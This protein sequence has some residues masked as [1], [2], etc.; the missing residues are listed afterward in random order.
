MEVVATRLP[1]VLVVT[2]RTF[3]DDRGEFWETYH[4][5]RYREA[6]IPGPLVQDNQSRSRRG[7]VRGLHFQRTH[8]QAKLVW[9][10]RGEVFDVAV[11]LREGAPTYGEWIGVHLSASN[12]KQIYVPEGFA[13][14]FAVLSDEAEVTYKCSRLYAPGDEG[15]VRFDDPDLAIDWPV[16]DPVLSDKDLALPA[17]KM[18][19]PLA[20]VPG[21]LE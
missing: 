4:A 7:V 11:D 20:P 9:A 16:K 5:D 13:H 10:V 19:S 12:K 2:P 8:P 14:G 3:P 15:G 18:I 17:L 6:G 21:T 1:G